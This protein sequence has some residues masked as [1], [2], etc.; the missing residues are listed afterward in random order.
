MT[1]LTGEQA[2]ENIGKYIMSSHR[3]A[4]KSGQWGKITDVEYIHKLYRDVYVICWDD[5]I[6]DLW[7]VNDDIANYEFKESLMM[8]KEEFCLL[9]LV[10]GK[11]C[12][13]ANGVTV[14]LQSEEFAE[15]Y[16][17]ELSNSGDWVI[18]RREISKWETV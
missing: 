11:E 16:R 8:D 17:K 7:P 12:A 1:H 3:W 15:A 9:N 6:V 10:D 4:Y 2:K 14:T 18:M 5:D 13:Y